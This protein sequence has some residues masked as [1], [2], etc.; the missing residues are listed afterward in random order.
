MK[1]STFFLYFLFFIQHSSFAFII[2]P[3]EKSTSFTPSNTVFMFDVDGVLI[4]RGFWENWQE[5][6]HIIRDCNFFDVVKFLGWHLLHLPSL[7]NNL[8]NRD[9]DLYLDELAQEWPFLQQE[10]AQGT[11]LARIKRAI[12]VSKPLP[13]MQEILLNL[14]DQGYPVALTTNQSFST[15]KRIIDVGNLP[16]YSYYTLIFTSDRCKPDSPLLTR[17]P[18]KEYYQCFKKILRQQTGLTP[19]HYIFIDD[20]YKN[21]ISSAKEEIISIHVN[22]YERDPAQKLTDD[23]AQLGIIVQSSATKEKGREKSPA[24]AI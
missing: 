20:M 6:W 14:H 21:V 4:K 1:N 17:K 24:C 9:I 23:L 7:A 5:Y 10:T 11:I 15:L 8:Y 18:H 16:D 2:N 12:T 22:N 3:P 19:A 13:L